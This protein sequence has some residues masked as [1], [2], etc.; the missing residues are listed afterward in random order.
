MALEASRFSASFG[1]ASMVG[2]A[3]FDV[4]LSVAFSQEVQVQGGFRQEFARAV[5]RGNVR[6][7]LSIAA[8]RAQIANTLAIRDAL[9]EA[10]L[11]A[12][13]DDAATLALASDDG[14]A[15]NLEAARL[16]AV[17]S[18]PDEIGFGSHRWEFEG[19][20]LVVETDPS[21]E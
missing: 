15:W 20:S 19:S 11:P 3:D 8:R 16:L 18:S 2:A 13:D 6:T 12:A 4:S 7:R 21:G 14:G 10:A 1:E 9:T 17:D 5:P